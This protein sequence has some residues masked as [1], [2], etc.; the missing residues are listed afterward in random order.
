M[1]VEKGAKRK[2]LPSKPRARTSATAQ[3]EIDTE[4]RQP[5]HPF[6]RLS[7]M[8]AAMFPAA[9][10]GPKP[11]A[12]VESLA[13]APHE[14]F[15]LRTASEGPAPPA[16][17]VVYEDRPIAVLHRGTSL[18]LPEVRLVGLNE[19]GAGAR[20]RIGR[21]VLAFARDVVDSLV[22]PLRKAQRQAVSAAAKGLLYRLEQ[23]LGTDTSALAEEHGAPFEA[24]AE[25]DLAVIREAGVVLGRRAAWVPR[26]FSP[27]AM[28]ARLAITLAYSGPGARLPARPPVGPSIP[29]PRGADHNS[30]SALGYVLAGRRAVRA[31]VLDRVLA[32]RAGAEGAEPPG[33][34]VLA[35][36]LACSPRDVPAILEALFP[37]A[38]APQGEPGDVG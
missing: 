11:D 31:D 29:A 25:A 9:S 35:R 12:W 18:L 8:R 24:P 5:H 4:D 1:A 15:S 32:A 13:T 2:V 33:D 38:E 21:R 3:P 6:A 30:Y 37:P 7:A 19:L 26:L 28:A 14:A 27:A 16:A 34:A 17:R 20:A 10:P 23:G 36:W 22:G